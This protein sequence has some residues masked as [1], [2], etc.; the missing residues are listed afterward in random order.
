MLDR[1]HRRYGTVYGNG[2]RYV[3]AEHVRSHA[4]FDALR[5]ADMIV[6]DTW[7]S[8]GLELIGHEIKVSRSDWLH[9]LKQ[10]EKAEQFIRYCNRW[11]LVVP[12]AAIVREELPFGWG[13][14]VAN[15]TGCRAVRP[16]PKLHADPM[17]RSMQVAML[18]AVDKTTASRTDR[19][20]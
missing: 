10:R 20:S 3:C 18:R 13:L 14:M 9:E 12:D 1:L 16:A 6:Q 7:P 8:K 5:T 17:P 15:D 19:I 2:Q 11:W 4:G